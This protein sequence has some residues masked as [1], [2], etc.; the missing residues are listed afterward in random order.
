MRQKSLQAS[1]YKLDIEN[2]EY[3]L[4]TYRVWKTKM[5]TFKNRRAKQEQSWSRKL[6]DE[7]TAA[8]NAYMELYVALLPLRNYFYPYYCMILKL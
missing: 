3:D 5:G 6:A 2:L 7:S 1:E 8:A 4:T